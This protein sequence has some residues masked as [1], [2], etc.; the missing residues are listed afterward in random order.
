MTFAHTTA[1]TGRSIRDRRRKLVTP[2][3]ALHADFQHFGDEDLP[4]S[5]IRLVVRRPNVA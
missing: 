5:D 4:V 2:R 3:S 1:L